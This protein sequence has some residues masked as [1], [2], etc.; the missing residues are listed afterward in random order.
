MK[1]TQIICDICGKNNSEKNNRERWSH[2]KYFKF[3]GMIVAETELDFCIS[4]AK[5]IDKFIT[6]IKEAK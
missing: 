6:E 2:V 4:C 1:T 5:K 3:F